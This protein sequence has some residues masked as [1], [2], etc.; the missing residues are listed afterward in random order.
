MYKTC[1][2]YRVERQAIP[3]FNMGSMGLDTVLM[4]KLG[5]RMP[6]HSQA[7][8]KHSTNRCKVKTYKKLMI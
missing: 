6:L 1:P 8:T 4:I 7:V 3:E 2:K 5:P